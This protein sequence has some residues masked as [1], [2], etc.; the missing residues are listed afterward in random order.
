MIYTVISAAGKTA[1]SLIALVNKHLSE[2]WKCT[3]GVYVIP[4]IGAL[5]FYYQAM[6]KES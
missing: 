5:N 3:G 2:G 4:S 6:V 1:D